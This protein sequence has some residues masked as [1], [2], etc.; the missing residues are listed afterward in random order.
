MILDYSSSSART[1]PVAMTFAQT[2]ER[3]QQ[4]Q[5]KQR[6]KSWL[7]F[8]QASRESSQGIEVE[9]TQVEQ[10]TAESRTVR[11]KGSSKDHHGWNEQEEDQDGATRQFICEA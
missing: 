10:N 7:Q 9:E 1:N 2:K 8:Q 11:A 4:R 6:S 3:H 5:Q